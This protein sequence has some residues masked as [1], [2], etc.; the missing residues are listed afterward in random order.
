MNEIEK[1]ANAKPEKRKSLLSVKERSVVFG[2]LYA[3][4]VAGLTMLLN[5]IPAPKEDSTL[6]LMFAVF[7]VVIIALTIV[8]ERFVIAKLSLRRGLFFVT[9]QL[10]MLLAII[11]LAIIGIN[12]SGDEYYQSTELSYAM[13][14]CFN[15]LVLLLYHLVRCIVRAIIASQNEKKQTKKKRR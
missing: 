14:F 3:L 13:A 12:T 1:I 9:A 6:W 11:V 4:I 7:Y 5:L 8:L 10:L 15:E 2:L